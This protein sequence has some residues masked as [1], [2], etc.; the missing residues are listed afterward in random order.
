[1]CHCSISQTIAKN[2]MSVR[3]KESTGWTHLVETHKILASRQ[4]A[5]VA[6]GIIDSVPRIPID[7][8]VANLSN[9]CIQQ[10]KDMKV[11]ECIPVPRMWLEPTMEEDGCDNVGFVKN[12]KA[13]KSKQVI[14]DKLDHTTKQDVSLQE[15]H[16][17]DTVQF[18]KEVCDFRH[19]FGERIE[20]FE[21]M[22]D[23]HLCQITAAKHRT[24]LSPPDALLMYSA[25][26]C[27]GPKHGELERE[28]VKKMWKVEFADSAITEWASPIVSVP[29]NDRSL[30][31]CVH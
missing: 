6:Q 5:L 3:V 1:M 19:L 18:N 20:Q 21:S 10:F 29:K 23:S 30:C 25:S 27:V 26:Y 22:C 7:T 11:A 2:E 16:R 12:Y 28:E 9:S 8:K 15:R 24:V 4:Q 31:F 14:K 13:P 17:K